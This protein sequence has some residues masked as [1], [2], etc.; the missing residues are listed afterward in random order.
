MNGQLNGISAFKTKEARKTTYLCTFEEVLL[1]INVEVSER[2]EKVKQTS[3]R[4]LW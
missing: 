3:G 4:K 2:K 1:L